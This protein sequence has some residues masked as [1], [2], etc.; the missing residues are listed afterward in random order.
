VPEPLVIEGM[1]GY[2]ELDQLYIEV[3]DERLNT[4]NSSKNNYFNYS[5]LIITK[6]E[7]IGETKQEKSSNQKK[8][9]W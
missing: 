6:H 8:I 1:L 2:N 4:I 7:I 3:L 9:L 5:K